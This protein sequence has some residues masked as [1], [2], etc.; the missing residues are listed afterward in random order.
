MQRNI[1]ESPA[2]SLT[3][4]EDEDLDDYSATLKAGTETMN[5]FESSD[6]DSSEEELEEGNNSLIRDDSVQKSSGFSIGFAEDKNKKYRRS[7]EDSHSFFYNFG[8]VLGSGWFAIFDGHAGKST[9]EHCGLY[10]HENFQK[11][12][13]ESPDIPIPELLNKTFIQ[14]DK[15]LSE[16]KGLFS[17]ATAIVAYI[18]NEIKNDKKSRVLYTANAGDSRAVLCRDG[19]AVRLSYD[20][21]GSDNQEVKRIMEAG[22]FVM[23]NRVNGVLAVTRSLGD[24]SMKEWVIGSPYTM[25]TVL[26]PTDSMLILACDGLWDVCSDQTAIDLIKDESDPQEASSKLLNYALQNMSTDNLSILCIKFD[27]DFLVRN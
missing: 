7:M 21:K 25:E 4:F 24:I 18:R 10:L 22:G 11:N 15:Q 20:H 6:D 23:N 14:T 2:S 17:G 3:K 12:L 16:K 5:Q 1:T 13:K 8:N 9:A 26:K 19:V 27:K